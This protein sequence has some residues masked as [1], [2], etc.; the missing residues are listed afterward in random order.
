[1][2]T[3]NLSWQN[4]QY[5]YSRMDF[6]SGIYC[7]ISGSIY[8][9]KKLYILTA[10]SLSLISALI[11][12]CLA[13]ISFFRALN[14]ACLV[15]MYCSLRAIRPNSS[16]TPAHLASRRCTDSFKSMAN[17]SSKFSWSSS[18]V[19]G[20]S[21]EK[22]NCRLFDLNSDFWHGSHKWEGYEVILAFCMHFS[23]KC[24]FGND[25]HI[26]RTLWKL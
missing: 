2:S 9:S 8:E 16:R 5:L 6:F 20:S 19:D 17:S 23:K 3:L 15:R 1:M 12:A 26:L 14:W 10:A 7:A 22:I 11:N 4:F 21:T 18:A 25:Y 24:L 13:S